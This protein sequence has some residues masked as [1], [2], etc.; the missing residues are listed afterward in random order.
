MY[1]P[2]LADRGRDYTSLYLY[3]YVCLQCI[4]TLTILVVN[5]GRSCTMS[6][7]LHLNISLN[8]HIYQG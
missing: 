5:R 3:I 8:A 7:I 2:L 1:L 4:S 6:N